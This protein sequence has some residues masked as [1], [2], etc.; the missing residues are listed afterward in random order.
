MI[1]KNEGSES[2]LDFGTISV[3]TE[4]R[5]MQVAAGEDAEI[6]VDNVTITNS[7]NTISD[8]IAGATLNLVGED[9]DTTVTLKV[10]RDL[11]TIK[12]KIEDMVSAYN[13]IM[14]YINIQFTYD[15]DT[16]QVGGILFGDGT[17]STIK[18]ELINTVTRTITGASGDYNKLAHIGITLD[19]VDTDEGEYNKLNL[20]IDDDG[21]DDN[22]LMDYLETNFDDVRKLFI[23]SG[24]SNMAEL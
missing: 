21:A 24:S 1:C 16:E 11:A 8:V 6:V 10:E 2:N 3:T 13:S 22:D 4:G 18:S 14:D 7:S 23:A 19:V 15:E 9:S 12:S 5:S 17:L 20:V